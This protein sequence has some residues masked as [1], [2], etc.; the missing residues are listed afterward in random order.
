MLQGSTAHYLTRSTFPLQVGHTCLIRAGA[1]GVG[2]LLIQLAK[3]WSACVIATI[4]TAEKAAIAKARGADHAIL[5][6]PLEIVWANNKED[7]GGRTICY[8]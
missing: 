7:V 1:G 6:L 2:Q 8:D 4:G 5:C 3:L